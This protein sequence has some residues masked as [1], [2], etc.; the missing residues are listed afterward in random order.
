[1]ISKSSRKQLWVSV[2]V[3]VVASI[4]LF[5][6]AYP[7]WQEYR[8]RKQAEQTLRDAA[9]FTPLPLNAGSYPK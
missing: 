5:I 9:H 3:V 2:A 8:E 1:M 7:Q 6:V 4:V